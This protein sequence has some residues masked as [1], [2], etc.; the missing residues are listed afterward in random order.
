MITVNRKT[1][2]A[3]MI[4]ATA[5]VA[6]ACRG[7]DGG[8]GGDGEV[9]I[10]TGVSNEA[11]PD[12]PN[13]DNGCITLGI[14]TD[15]TGPFSP[16]AI[17]VTD[18][19]KAFWKRVNEEG[20]IKAGDKAYDV[21]V[22]SHV[23][24]NNYNPQT[25]REKFKKIE[26]D[27]LG[28]AQTLGSPMTNAILK[29]LESEHIVSAP[30]SWSS[31][32][33]F[34]DVVMESGA[35]YCIESM[36]AVDYAVE[37]LK[38]KSVM[39][40]HYPG[41]YG[42]DAAGGAKIAAEANKLKFTDVETAPGEES[43]AGAIRSIVTQKPDVVIVS[44]GPKEMATIVGKAAA[45]GFTGKFIGTS[46]TWN[47]GLLKSAAAPALEK[48]FLQSAPWGTFTSDTPGH[49]A[50]RNALGDVEANDG[51]TAGWA[52]SYPMKAVLEKAAAD[53]DLTREGLHNAAK[54]LDTVDYEGMLPEGAGNY[55][56]EPND[57][58]FRQTIINKVDKKAGT[59][60][61]EVKPFFTGPT[62]EKFELTKK[63]F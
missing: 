2:I 14:I 18:G 61:S 51:Y 59:G 15:E 1:V 38:A 63:C 57:I 31:E 46:P 40:V 30:A 50:M 39:A 35:P 42:G 41:D 23:E 19:Q 24:N 62:A 45:G 55:V 7:D 4:S 56:G 6:V 22:T 43:Q 21:D 33:L 5:L 52:W 34:T 28:L 37:D 9:K 8:G 26:G 53:G 11:C 54:E 58:V 13:K 47:P 44:T 17:P 48:L 36:N 16:L 32:W 29:D 20:G 10:G 3:A 60:V 12:S 27:V 49:E 25:H